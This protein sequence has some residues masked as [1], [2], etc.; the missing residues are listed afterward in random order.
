MEFSKKLYTHGIIDDKEKTD[1]K[2]NY[3]YCKDR[4]NGIVKLILK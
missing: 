1:I 4:N 2:D 3:D